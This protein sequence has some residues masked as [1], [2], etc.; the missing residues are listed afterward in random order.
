MRK[1]SLRK[2]T[3]AVAGSV[4]ALLLLAGCGTASEAGGATS[5]E[6][7]GDAAAAVEPSERLAV[8]VDGSVLVLDSATLEV[9]EEFSSEAFTRLNA[10]GDGRNV[11]VTT[12]TGFQVLDTQAP[13][14]TDLEF[15]AEAAGHV[16]RH[17]GK[18]VLYADGTGETTIFDTDALVELAGAQLPEVTT[19]RADAA[20]H[21]VSIVLEDGTLVT[22][23]G[24]ATSRSGAVAL[25]PHDDHYDEIAI[26]DECPGIHGE[27][28]AQDEAVIFG[29]ENGALLYQDGAF[30]KFTAPDAYG[31]MGNA[32][33]SE[34]SPIVVGD[35][36]HDPDAEGYLLHEVAL[37]DTAA[38]TYE[39]VE[40]DGVEYTWRGV[41][42]G[43]EDL[44]YILGTDGAIHVLDPASGEI[45]AAHPVIDPWQGP[46]DWQEPHPAMTTDGET[47]YIAD[48][49][50]D[51]VIAVDLATGEVVAE[52]EALPAAPNEMAVNLG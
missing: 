42:R 45:T 7:T 50:N 8:S 47:A 28:T 35:Y 19:H 30:E 38:R 6:P 13:E 31:R 29:C 2:P 22:T 32:Y 52:S 26:S 5:G 46:S 25:E 37:I 51:R 21:G 34:T 49:A 39:V 41:V 15:P 12:S 16:V 33:V 24:D 36:K 44:A 48:V 14:L 17:G 43:P 20:H 11:L 18:T 10:V 23:V 1:T 27:G 4:A 40:L 9:V 3:L